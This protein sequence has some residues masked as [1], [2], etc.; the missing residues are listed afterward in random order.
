MKIKKTIFIYYSEYNDYVQFFIKEGDYRHLNNVYVNG[1]GEENLQEELSN[2][3]FD[4]EGELCVKMLS[5]FPINEVEKNIAVITCG[6][7]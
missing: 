1:I 6:F 2:I 5:D 4:N 3:I 7:V